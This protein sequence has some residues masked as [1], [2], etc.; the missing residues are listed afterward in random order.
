[1]AHS[2]QSSVASSISFSF[3]RVMWYISLLLCLEIISIYTVAHTLSFIP[4]I[5]LPPS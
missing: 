3:N 4:D 5:F 2:S 1:V